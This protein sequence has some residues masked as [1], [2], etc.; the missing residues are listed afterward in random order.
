MG[1]RAS[2]PEDSGGW[3]PI[4]TLESRLHAL[5]ES[6]EAK[7]AMEVA[8][9]DLRPLSAEVDAFLICHGTSRRHVKALCEAARESLGESGESVLFVEGLEEG[10]WVLIDCGDFLV[11]VFSEENRAFYRLE[12][13]WSHASVIDPAAAGGPGRHHESRGSG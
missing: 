5:R 11:H 9:L 1:I 2:F 6:L 4:E 12:D 10:G 13:L 7:K 8:L 3:R